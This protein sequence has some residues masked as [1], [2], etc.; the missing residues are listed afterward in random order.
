MDGKNQPDD[1][2]AAGDA[3]CTPPPLRLPPRPGAAECADACCADVVDG[4]VARQRRV[5]WAVLLINAAMFAVEIG[6]GLMAGSA[7][8]QADALDFLADAANYALS[9]VVVGMTLRARAAAALLKGVSMG[10]LGLWVLAATGWHAW[11]QTLPEAFTMGAVGVAALLA[12]G[13][14]FALLWRYR[15]GDA[16]MHSAWICTRNDVLGN[17]AVLL[18]AAGVF[19][20][21]AG[22]PD[23]V[24][25]TIMA[26]LGLQ[27][28]LVVVRRA[29]G[30]LARTS[31]MSSS[32]A[33]S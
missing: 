27:G 28:A 32:G 26:A 19:G 24:V 21:S 33:M 4:S 5:L 6:A 8:L 9:L 17:C 30:D 1:C 23:L 15:S 7:S 3:C 10:A 18:A 20:T 13:A 14:S 16:N 29:A 11:H 22:W 12:N 31:A 2:C 25:A